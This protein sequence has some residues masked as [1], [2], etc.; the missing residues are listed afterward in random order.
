MS[1]YHLIVYKSALLLMIG[2]LPVSAQELAHIPAS[3]LD[4]GY[5]ARP[6]GMGRAYTA[7][8]NDAYALNWNPAGLMMGSDP[9]LSFF[10]TRQ[11]NLIPYSMAVYAHPSGGRSWTHGEGLIVSGDDALRETTLLFG[12]AYDMKEYVSHLIVGSTVSY[13]IASFGNNSDGGA[14]Q[15]T[16]SGVGLSV[17]IGL[18]YAFSE[19]ISTGVVLRNVINF[20][21][22]NT[23]G[24][25]SYAQGNPMTM[26]A[27]FA[28]QPD[29]QTVFAL[30]LE[31]AMHQDTENHLHL[32]LER[33]IHRHVNV[34]GGV[35]QGLNALSG[36]QYSIGF[37]INYSA[38]FAE[39]Q[40]DMAYVLQDLANTL[41]VS[42]SFT[43][44]NE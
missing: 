11:F 22:W 10:H 14:G 31:K 9:R 18:L 23:T 32:G 21:S 17:D 40:V 12:L 33:N 38:S 16:G 43:F 26:R 19:W 29:P 3:F 35:A 36:I 41:Y 30:D 8:A 13:H 5:G 34:R 37:G 27:G 7:L 42:L 20:M 1:K 25:G 24:L 44:G 6:M 4:I 28:L 39:T 2:L 15:I